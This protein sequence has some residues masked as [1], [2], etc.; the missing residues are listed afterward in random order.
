MEQGHAL[1]A[2]AEA[3]SRGLLAMQFVKS[4]LAT[5][6]C[7]R[8]VPGMNLTTSGLTAHQQI[9]R[10]RKHDLV[11]V[12][13]RCREPLDHRQAFLVALLGQQ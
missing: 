6:I 7:R 5:E 2:S 4:A 11:C 10:P 3:V 8:R 9:H 12:G 1:R 13:R